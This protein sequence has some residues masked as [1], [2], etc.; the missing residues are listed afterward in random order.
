[1]VEN[2]RRQGQEGAERRF[3]SPRYGRTS[4]KIGAEDLIGIREIIDA[5]QYRCIW[6]RSCIESAIELLK[7]IC[8]LTILRSLPSAPQRWEVEVSL[9]S[10]EQASQD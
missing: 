7:G 5:Q 1:M 9:L 3:T 10:Q 8:K 4:D 6:A 2:V